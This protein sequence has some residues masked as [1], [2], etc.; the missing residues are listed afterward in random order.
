MALSLKLTFSSQNHCKKFS[1]R[2]ACLGPCPWG[3]EEE[4]SYLPEGKI[5]LSR[6]T[7]RGFFEPCKHF[8]VHQKYSNARSIFNSLL[9]EI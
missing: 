1:Q 8:E 4:E 9:A 3:K 5:Y 6:T 2:T 7:G